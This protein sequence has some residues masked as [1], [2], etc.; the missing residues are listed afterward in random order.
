LFLLPSRKTS[1]GAVPGANW[2]TEFSNR[3]S[4][5]NMHIPGSLLIC[6]PKRYIILVSTSVSIGIRGIEGTTLGIN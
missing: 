6:L 3:I 4:V 5:L 2:V 1:K